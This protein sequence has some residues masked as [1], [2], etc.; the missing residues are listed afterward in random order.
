MFSWSKADSSWNILYMVQLITS[1]TCTAPVLNTLHTYEIQV[2]S[3]S[4]SPH[5]NEMFKNKTYIIPLIP[6]VGPCDGCRT[7]AK[8]F[9]FLCALRAWTRPIVVVLLPSPSGVGVILHKEKKNVF[10]HK[11]VIIWPERTVNKLPP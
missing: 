3:V 1:V 5:I 9:L 6:N 8:E 10:R 4:F 2:L 11:Y 7:H